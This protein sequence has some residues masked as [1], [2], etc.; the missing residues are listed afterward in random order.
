MEWR[1]RKLLLHL[2]LLAPRRYRWI[3]LPIPPIGGEGS[4]GGPFPPWRNQ[5][6]P[7]FEQG[8]MRG[9]GRFPLSLVFHLKSS[10]EP[11]K[12]LTERRN[13]MGKIPALLN[14]KIPALLNSKQAF[15]VRSQASSLRE[16][17]FPAFELNKS[18]YYIYNSSHLFPLPLVESSLPH[19]LVERLRISKSY[20]KG[21]YH[22]LFLPLNRSITQALNRS[23]TRTEFDIPS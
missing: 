12:G 9:S 14:S 11:P 13:L 17:L 18:P 20:A 3:G 6:F 21:W 8:L 15:L 5:S 16:S 2:S 1:R 23:I 4:G 19:P 10:I 22:L 7:S